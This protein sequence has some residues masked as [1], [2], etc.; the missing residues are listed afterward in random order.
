MEEKELEPNQMEIKI[1]FCV[2]DC[3]LHGKVKKDFSYPVTGV[4]DSSHRE[5][6]I[7]ELNEMCTEIFDE[8]RKDVLEIFKT[9]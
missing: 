2:N 1:V 7:N 4:I 9:I 6:I 3:R 5:T 8:F